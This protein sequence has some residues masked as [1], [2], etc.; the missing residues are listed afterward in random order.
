MRGDKTGM[1]LLKSYILP[2]YIQMTAAAVLT[3]VLRAN[4]AVCGYES[5]IGLMMIALGGVSTAMWG[6]IYQLRYGDKR[7]KEIFLDFFCF[8]V[9]PKAYGQAAVFLTVDFL[10]VILFGRLDAGVGTLVALFV[11]A[12]AFGGIEELGWR[13][14]FQPWV[15][16]RISYVPATLLTF[17][18]WGIWHF[19]FF[20]ID[21]SISAVQTLPFCV[22]LLTNCFI[23]SAL[24][25][26]SKNLWLCVMTHAL[27]NTFAQTTSV[28]N[29]WIGYVTSALI[30][31][32]A[33]ILNIKKPARAEQ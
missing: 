8:K 33:I 10:G 3:Y 11:K 32:F 9:D 29:G 1:K 30:I 22:G 25:N 27:I 5:G 13:Y 28:E 19:M 7:P 14:T 6:C 26:S 16:K 21:G 17:L 31:A 12:I 2:V 20:Y 24:Y 15:E 23:L 4:G 18:C